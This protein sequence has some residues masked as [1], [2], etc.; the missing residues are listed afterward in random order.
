ML[1]LLLLWFIN[2]I[3]MLLFWNIVGVS[4]TVSWSFLERRSWSLK[5]GFFGCSEV[6]VGG[7]GRWGWVVVDVRRDG[8]VSGSFW[9]DGSWDAP[10][11]F[12]TTDRKFDGSACTKVVFGWAVGSDPYVG[13]C[14]VGER[15][16]EG[17]W[18][19]FV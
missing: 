14:M 6:A 12:W 10:V 8:S 3:M 2:I 16:R 19:R 9:A 5:L 4:E 17:E 11:S 15:E 1:L 18:E 7:G 13:E